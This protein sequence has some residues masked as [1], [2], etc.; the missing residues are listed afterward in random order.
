M[1]TFHNI[2]F[3]KFDFNFL[4]SNNTIE[5][6][7]NLPVFSPY[8]KQYNNPIKDKTYNNTN[9]IGNTIRTSTFIDSSEIDI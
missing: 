8:T 7:T 5:I 2:V 4:S 3:E 9:N 1:A 6:Y